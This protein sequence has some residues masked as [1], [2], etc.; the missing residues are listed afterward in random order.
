MKDLSTAYFAMLQLPKRARRDYL[1]EGDVHLL[2]SPP[3]K[4]RIL[5]L[6]STSNT[7]A[8]AST[9]NEE[10]KEVIEP[11]SI[12]RESVIK[13]AVEMNQLL[14]VAGLLRSHEYMQLHAL[15]KAKMDTKSDVL[16]DSQQV[17]YVRTKMESALTMLDAG[18]KQSAKSLEDR[19]EFCK[20]LQS[21]S[22]DWCFQLINQV[23]CVDTSF[24][25]T[26]AQPLVDPSQ[27][28]PLTVASDATGV[29]VKDLTIQSDSDHTSSIIQY[30]LRM[31]LLDKI[32][33]R[34]IATTCAWNVL[35][36]TE[37]DDVSA[38]LKRKRHS[39]L[40]VLAMQFLL[41]D[42]AVTSHTYI[43]TPIH[44]TMEAAT[45]NNNTSNESLFAR[46]VIEPMHTFI[47]CSMKSR[48]NIAIELS[49]SCSLIMSLVPIQT[50][51][52][53]TT[54]FKHDG[55]CGALSLLL[56]DTIRRSIKHNTQN[57]TTL[58]KEIKKNS[59]IDEAIKPFKQAQ[60]IA[61]GH[62]PTELGLVRALFDGGRAI[63]LELVCTSMLDKISNEK[64]AR[65]T[66]ELSN[67]VELE[68]DGNRKAENRL[69]RRLVFA[70]ASS[71]TVSVNLF[72]GRLILTDDKGLCFVCATAVALENV[73][74]R[75]L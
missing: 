33:M 54:T 39:N 36:E 67:T 62:L 30:T 38:Y 5:E 22:R 43:V 53:T 51:S 8:T 73:V 6:V 65:I 41:D 19:R 2:E 18:V 46:L 70:N 72:E 49:R 1:V 32:S 24:D 66:S 7:T 40:C 3:I 68:M 26:A 11:L 52:S 4:Q 9:N 10:V 16:T 55:L 42:L 69:L 75:Y 28:V 31:A 60:L 71:L 56:L 37:A 35:G 13:A 15:S 58:L 25:R 44:T 20:G 27:L 17:Q 59:L 63:L 21:L 61:A 47:E 29:C 64:D 34:F 45:S 14:N 23:V 48:S 74:R 50:S 12:V 57:S